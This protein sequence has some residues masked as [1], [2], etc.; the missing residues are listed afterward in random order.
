MPDDPYAQARLA[1]EQLLSRFGL[2]RLDTAFVLGSGWSAAADH[3]GEPLG[4][5][6]LAELPGFAQPVVVGHGGLLKLVRT[7]AGRTAAILTGRTHFYECRGVV[8]VCTASAR[9]RRPGRHP[10]CSPTVVGA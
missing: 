8:P 6:R 7:P 4:E 5:C 9:S 1:A 3:L 10:W 2:E